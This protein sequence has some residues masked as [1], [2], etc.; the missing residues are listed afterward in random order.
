MR[1][2]ISGTYGWKFGQREESGLFTAFALGFFELRW[3][4]RGRK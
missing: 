4:N 2:T 1:L 3:W